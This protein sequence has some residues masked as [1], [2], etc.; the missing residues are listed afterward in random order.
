LIFASLWS[1]DEP[2]GKLVKAGSLDNF[3]VKA[4]CFGCEPIP[5][6]EN[7]LMQPHRPRNLSGPIR[8]TH[9]WWRGLAHQPEAPPNDVLRKSS[10][11]GRS[12]QKDDP[13][14]RKDL[15]ARVRREIEAG[16]YDTDEKWEA[17]LDRLIDRMS[18]D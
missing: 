6:G 5:S 3:A 16:T 9:A 14:I 1:Y 8:G 18:E 10:G 4:G 13:A 12:P 7:E 2:D 15:V 11:K 17:A